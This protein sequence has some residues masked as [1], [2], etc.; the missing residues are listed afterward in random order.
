VSDLKNLLELSDCPDLKGAK[1]Y[2][3]LSCTRKQRALQL[4]GHTDE[5]VITK[6]GQKVAGVL[7]YFRACRKTFRLMSQWGY[8]R[9]V[10][11][12]AII[13]GK[14]FTWVWLLQPIFEINALKGIIPG[15][16]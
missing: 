3:A 16:Y 9:V 2:L 5:F 11:M 4:D 10:R 1:L 8:I 13:T 12:L 14:C 15:I 7:L 6:N